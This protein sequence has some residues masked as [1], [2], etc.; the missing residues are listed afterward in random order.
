MLSVKL[1]IPE[2]II[3]KQIEHAKSVLVVN[4]ETLG[5][6]AT[7]LHRYYQDVRRI[8][9]KTVDY[10]AYWYLINTPTVTVGLNTKGG[11]PFWAVT[12]SA[13]LDDAILSLSLLLDRKAKHGTVSNLR[14]CLEKSLFD[15][16]ALPKIDEERAKR[17]LGWRNKRVA[18]EDIQGHVEQY[19]CD[20]AILISE[21]DELLSWIDVNIFGS[22]VGDLHSFSSYSVK[23]KILDYDNLSKTL[24]A[25]GFEYSKELSQKIAEDISPLPE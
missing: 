13:L 21:L 25:L 11:I 14:E 8:R 15:L 10:L 18:H 20:P 19:R 22:N 24:S 2:D 1:N 7:N 17:I 9:S 12:K 6:L 3:E 5:A 4:H 23:S 16:S